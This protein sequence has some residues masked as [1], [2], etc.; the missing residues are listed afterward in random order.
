MQSAAKKH[1]KPEFLNRFDEIIV[2]RELNKIHLR[3]IIDIE[4]HKIQTRLDERNITL[5]YSDEVKDY[6]I[7]QGYKPEYGARPLRRAVERHIED[8]L[9][10][11]I[12]RSELKPNSIVE[13]RLDANKLS[14]SSKKK[15]NLNPNPGSVDIPSA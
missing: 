4:L 1:F 13:I 8:E 10:E 6:L 14:S 12:L 15:K 9:A 3:T 2:F 7:E 5:D 11:L